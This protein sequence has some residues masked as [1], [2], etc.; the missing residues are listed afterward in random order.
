MGP[1]RFPFF[2]API[3]RT[4]HGKEVEGEE[5]IRKEKGGAGPQKEE[6]SKVGGEEIRE[7]GSEKSREKGCAQGCGQGRSEARS[8]A[9]SAGQ[10]AGDTHARTSSGADACSGVDAT[11]QWLWR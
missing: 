3:G 9:Q 6:N 11:G 1:T 10:E 7:E 8:E 5:E 4:D 2:A